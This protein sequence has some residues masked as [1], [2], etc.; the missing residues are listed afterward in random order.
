[1]RELDSRGMDHG[2][3][4]ELDSHLQNKLTS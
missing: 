4:F 1:V 3:G 2:G